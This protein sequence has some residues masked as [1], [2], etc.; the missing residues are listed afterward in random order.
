MR[1]WTAPYW[2]EPA[3]EPPENERATAVGGGLPQRLQHGETDQV[4]IK[5]RKQDGEIDQ[6]KAP[7]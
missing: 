2:T 5:V 4:W 3:K 1:L 7:P 6:P